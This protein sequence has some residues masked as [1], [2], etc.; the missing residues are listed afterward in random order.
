MPAAAAAIEHLTR[1]TALKDL[2]AFAKL[3]LALEPWRN[4]LVFIGGWAHRLHRLDPRA[5]HLEYNPVFTRDTDIAFG[6]R[7]PLEGDIKQALQAQGFQ[8]QLS[9]EFRP[10][11]AQYNLGQENLGFYA[12]FLTPLAGSGEKRNGQKD[13]TESRA[14]IVA[15]KV[16]HLDVLLVDPWLIRCGPV[17]GIPLKVPMDVQV[18][19][20]LCFMVQKFLI[21]KDRKQAKR[22]QDLLYIYDT[23]ELF[24]AMIPVF[25]ENWKAVIAPSLGRQ[26]DDIR[27]ISTETFAAVDDVIRIAARIPQDRQ[28]DPEV[29][30]MACQYAFGEILAD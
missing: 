3:V 30:Q 16:R 8:E 17:F 27:R 20:P 13:A 7:T 14:R 18:A 11:V 2:D 9:G 1:T 5:N 29:L 24:G 15:Q 12:E 21:Q 28:L 22:A 23:L 4:S 10:P 19:N 6:R 25:A 26:S